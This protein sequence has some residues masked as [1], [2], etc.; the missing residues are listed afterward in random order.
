MFNNWRRLL[1]G[2]EQRTPF[3]HRKGWHEDNI[4][5]R[6]SLSA[7]KGLGGVF[8][9][10]TIFS[11]YSGCHSSCLQSICS[12]ALTGCSR[13]SPCHVLH[14]WF[15]GSGAVVP[16][17]WSS[18]LSGVVGRR[19]LSCSPLCGGETMQPRN[20]R[21][22]CLPWRRPAWAR[23]QHTEEARAKRVPEKPSAVP[24]IYL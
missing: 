9:A 23:G 14:Q 24:L 3:T 16:S 11:T 8:H 18:R 19:S 5:C 7:F 13:H 20:C 22:S 12:S 1:S 21:L 2:A 10:C 6:D 15:V 17:E 4:E